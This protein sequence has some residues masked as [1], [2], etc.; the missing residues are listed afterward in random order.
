MTDTTASEHLRMKGKRYRA[1]V[2]LA[3][4]TTGHMVNDFYNMVLPPLLPALL[5]AFKMNYF[6]V[7]LLSFCFYILS[8]I[9]QPT[10][11]YLADKH[12]IRKRIVLAGL[13]T[14]CIGFVAIGLSPSYVLVLFASLLCGLGAAT[15][16]PQSTNFLTR[17]FPEAKG[18]AMGIHGWGGSIGN[19]LA[20]L[21]VAY[22]VS[23]FGWRQGVMLLTLPGLLV[24]VLL[25]YILDEPQ[26]AKTAGFSKGISK[27][28]ILLSCTFALLSMV[29]RGFLTFLPTFLVARGSS[30]SQAGFITSLMLFVGLVAQPLGG[31]VYDKVGGRAIFFVS[32]LAT[33]I[34]MLA[35]TLSAGTMLIAWTMIVGFFIFALFPVALA[36]G[37]EVAKDDHVGVSVG[38]IF[39]FSSTLSAFTPV[40]TGYMAD[41]FGFNLSFQ[42]L[43]IFAA[44]A[45]LLSLALPGKQVTSPVITG[46]TRAS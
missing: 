35:F 44:L 4:L 40:F 37:S 21:A 28:L 32:S 25:W 31:H 36:M 3:G 15:F 41:L 6:Q 7:G 33:G 10:M 18:Q 29:L 22:V 14:Y 5:V 20:P 27:D 46:D 16:H 43:V 13:L 17:A 8:G 30:L 19:F 9:L 24:I 11:G 26:D 38:V 2:L 12:A 23:A 45:A 42:F 39:G 1:Y 34:A